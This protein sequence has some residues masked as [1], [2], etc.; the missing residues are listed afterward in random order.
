MKNKVFYQLKKVVFFVILIFI[1]NFNNEVNAQPFSLDKNIK[2]IEL[3]LQPY[4]GN[5]SAFN[6]K[7]IAFK[8]KSQNDTAYYFVKGCGIYQP[9]LF[10]IEC[11]DKKENVIVNLCK[12][13]WKKP[14]QKGQTGDNAEWQYAFKTEGSF[15]I[16]VITTKKNTPY[17]II[18]WLGNEPKKIIMPSPFK[19]IKK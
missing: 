7:A 10:K 6:G 18:V 9:V 3:K 8:T 5:D 13:N 17:R 4:K 1:V 16:Q 12:N 14:D 2:P 11:L 15:G 19:T